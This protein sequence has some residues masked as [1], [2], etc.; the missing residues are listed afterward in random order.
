MSGRW[1]ILAL[2]VAGTPLPSTAQESRRCVIVVQEV[3][4]SGVQM[5][6]PDGINYFAGGGVHLTCRG[7]AVSMKSDS[8]AAFAGKVVQ[9]IGNVRYRDS[10]ATLDADFGTYYRDGERWEARG[11]VRS[12]SLANG[13]TL[14]GPSVDYLRVAKG[15]RDTSET[16]AI[17]RP[18]VRYVTRD[19]TGTAQEPYVIVGDRIR[20]RG[21]DRVWAGGK[22][23]IDRSDFA[24]RGDSMRLETGRKGSG[25]LIGGMPTIKGLGRDTFDL[26]GTRIDFGLADRE[27]TDLWARGE[28]HAV[29]RDLDLVADTIL[30]ERA[31]EKV[32]RT[33]AWGT[34]RR[35]VAVSDDYE[36]RAD[37]LAVD[38]PGQQLREVRAFRSAWIGTQVDSASGERDWI[39]GDTVR[40]SFA[41]RDSAGKEVTRLAQL[42][43]R[44]QAKSYYRAQEK[45]KEGAPRKLPSLNYARA[46]RIVVVMRESTEDD[47]V[48][49][50]DLFGNVDGI[51][52]DPQ[53]ESKPSGATDGPPR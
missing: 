18:T 39:A 45:A 17:G 38:T 37:S 24:A 50:V 4:D 46:D 35:A 28:G 27:L 2:L 53:R 36:V 30:I 48:E 13:S 1:G 21:D 8:V 42:E 14:E 11:N 32:E 23:T 34:T 29:T 25:T 40:A 19:S 6:T 16:F 33:R 44:A 43:S 51:Q 47:G 15:V 7:T 3:G 52:L 12:R 5:Q 26:T 31:D 41:Q 49:R 9:F 10:S 22:V 20:M